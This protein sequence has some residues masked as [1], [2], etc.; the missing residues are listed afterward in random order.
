MAER[1]YTLMHKN[2]QVV[3][4]IM[5]DGDIIAIKDVH[6]IRHLPVG[7]EHFAGKPV[8]SA[9]SNWWRKRGIPVSRSGLREGLEI[10]GVSDQKELLDKS[11][12]LS[13]SDQ[14]WINPS[15]RP[16]N[17]NDINFFDNAFS[18]DVG[19]ALFGD[20]TVSEQDEID[21]IS[22][23]G[24]SDG[25]LKKKW[26][27]IAGRRVL[28][29]SGSGTIMQEPCNE[30]L[31]TRLH[32]CLK[33]VRFAEYS[34]ILENGIPYSACE[35]FITK[36]L[37]LVSAAQILNSEKRR[38]DA[39]YYTHLTDICRKKGIESIQD[40]LDYLIITDYIIANT[41][42]HF[43]NFGFIRNAE[44]LQYEGIAPVYDSGT[45]LWHDVPDKYIDFQAPV[46]AKPFKKTQEE[47]IRMAHCFDWLDFS[48]LQGFVEEA[49]EILSQC[50]TITPERRDLITAGLL[51]RMK[52]LENIACNHLILVSANPL[53]P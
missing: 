7:V 51:D 30:V 3:D 29:K 13:L 16:L 8:R 10:L 32:M 21:F 2:I 46:K 31:A 27:I 14:Y 18:E 15:D 37:D 26:K 11:Y 40:F 17:W 34:M 12:G 50:P 4:F 43:N 35:T 45:S 23:C 48:L 19:N 5:D 28:V 22:P 9:L 41:D 44:T 1:N 39:S 33:R 42:R 49:N 20:C 53:L 24:A 52:R 36:D 47:Q 25:W 6:D 38:N